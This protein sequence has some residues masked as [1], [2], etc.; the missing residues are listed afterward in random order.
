MR[1][2]LRRRTATLTLAVVALLSLLSGCAPDQPSP[3]AP[4]S[5]LEKNPFPSDDEALAA[6]QATYERFMALTKQIA[7]EGGLA[8]ERIDD[9]A[10]PEVASTEK[11]GFAEFAARKLTITGD[12]IVRSAVLQSYSPRAAEGR[13]IV[14]G[15]FCI[16]VSGVDVLDEN[17]TSVVQPSRPDT[18]PYEVAF[19]LV[20]N[21][22][23][24]LIVSTKNVW[25][26]EGVC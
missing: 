19:D 3:P 1:L 25:R 22:P 2:I 13:A 21:D 15:Y 10:T 5:S 16:D 8:P 7:N 17:G 11:E 14:T 18:T 20:A 24:R 12:S 4:T 9:L 26:G 6:A 23:T